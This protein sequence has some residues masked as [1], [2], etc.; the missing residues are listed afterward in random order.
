[1]ISRQQGR[2]SQPPELSQ[3]PQPRMLLRASMRSG[4]LD[5]P[6]GSGSALPDI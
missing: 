6:G 1:M 3:R 5:A 4:H 2:L